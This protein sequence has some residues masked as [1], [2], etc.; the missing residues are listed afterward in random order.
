VEKPMPLSTLLWWNI[1]R[2]I[3]EEEQGGSARIEYG[4]QLIRQLARALGEEF[5]QGMSVANLRNFR[6]LYLTF[7]DAEKKLRTA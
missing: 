6:Q 1:G 2:R 3:L 5:G 7:P 4:S